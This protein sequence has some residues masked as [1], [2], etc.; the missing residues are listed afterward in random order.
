MLRASIGHGVTKELTCM[1]YGHEQ[2][3]GDC[4]RELWVI[5]GAQRG[6]IGVTLIA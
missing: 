6:K 3:R 2:R 4:W 1:T 5:G